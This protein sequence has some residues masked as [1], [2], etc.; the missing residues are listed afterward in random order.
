MGTLRGAKRAHEM[1]DGRALVHRCGFL[2][3]WRAGSRSE[4]VHPLA[5]ALLGA[6]HTAIIDRG[7]S[8]QA[9]VAEREWRSRLNGAEARDAPQQQQI[10]RIPFDRRLRFA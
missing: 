9:S 1:G 6:Y 5:I 8:L 7:S 2:I 10:A 3:V 4:S